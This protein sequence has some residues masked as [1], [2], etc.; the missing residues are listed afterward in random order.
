MHEYG[1]VVYVVDTLEKLAKEQQLTE[2]S[3][4]TLELGEV[5][6]ALP[7]YLYDAWKY[8]HK[9]SE[10]MKNA[11]LKIEIMPAITRCNHCGKTYSTVKYAKICPYCQS[12][13]TE[14]VTG[15]QFNIK[16]IEAR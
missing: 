15:N 4:V 12:E 5:S 7:D 6:S 10:V 9:Q 1:I 11:E 8:V 14:L 13:D 16:D 2:I 3:K